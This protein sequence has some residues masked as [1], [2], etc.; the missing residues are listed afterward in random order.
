MTQQLISGGN[1]LD[2]Q[3]HRQIKDNINENFTELY[4][5]TLNVLDKGLLGNDTNNDAVQLN[6]LISS[7]GS[8][9]TDIYFPSG[10][11][12]IASNVVLPSNVRL[13]MGYGAI[14]KVSNTYSITGTNTKIDA[15][16]YQIF[17]L[18]NGGTIIGSWDIKETYP[19]WFGAIGDGVAD[20]TV[21]I[22]NCIIFLNNDGVLC[23]PSGIYLI[24]SK[25]DIPYNCI[26]YFYDIIFTPSHIDGPVLNMD[27][28]NFPT[29]SQ[30]QFWI[31]G[32]FRINPK[33]LVNTLCGIKLGATKNSYI[34]NGT[35]TYNDGI[36]ETVLI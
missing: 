34:E 30:P 15:G 3:S 24:S 5:R 13:I 2:G 25:I 29:G 18:S 9:K 23:F 36:E 8:T 4:D 17:D 33:T 10:I 12:K 32:K 31:C 27:Y 20:D 19:H 21:A 22:N 16:L 28:D 6:A 35:I 1:G 14:L 7:I 26:V 11:Y